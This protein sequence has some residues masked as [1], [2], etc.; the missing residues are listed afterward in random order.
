MV[1]YK[2]AVVMV[3][4]EF[5]DS[6]DEEPRSGKTREWIKRRRESS[7][8][9]NIFQGWKVE[10]RLGFKDMFRISATDYETLLNQISK[11]ISQNERI[12]GNKFI[13]S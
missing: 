13:L 10:D 1:T 5:V 12:S 2:G 7:Y 6:D 3:L 11:L 8:F 4:T 9:Q